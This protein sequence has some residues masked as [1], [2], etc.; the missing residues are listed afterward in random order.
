VA[1]K[2]GKPRTP[3]KTSGRT[4]ARE[5]FV[6][7]FEQGENTNRRKIVT[8]SKN[9]K[10]LHQNRKRRGGKGSSS[11]PRSN[12]VLGVHR[13][14]AKKQPKKDH[15]GISACGKGV[16]HGKFLQKLEVLERTKDRQVMISRRPGQAGGGGNLQGT[17]PTL[18]CTHEVHE[19]G[20]ERVKQA[21]RPQLEDPTQ[22]KGGGGCH[23]R[24]G[25]KKV[26]KKPRLQ[27]K[28]VREK[29]KSHSH[30][31]KPAETGGEMRHPGKKKK[32][33]SVLEKPGLNTKEA[34]P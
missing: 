15:G 10:K 26:K 19:T 13:A 23:S 7:T 28:F 29:T 25:R 17:G 22:Q 4:K 1:L 12:H 30:S 11:F 21:P 20:R 16:D 2:L 3:L 14:R 33:G 9:I 34:L 8:K 6:L 31:T 24:G 5:I 32:N 18:G 27:G